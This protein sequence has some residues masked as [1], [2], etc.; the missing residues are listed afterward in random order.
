MFTAWAHGSFTTP[1]L[2]GCWLE[3]LNFLLWTKLAIEN[4]PSIFLNAIRMW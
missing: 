2:D 4:S 3:Y 1:I